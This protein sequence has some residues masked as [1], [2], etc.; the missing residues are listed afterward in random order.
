MPAKAL[1][2]EL[3]IVIRCSGAHRR[4]HMQITVRRAPG[5]GA[6]LVLRRRHAN[7]ALVDDIAEYDVRD[8][9]LKVLHR[10]RGIANDEA[11]AEALAMPGKSA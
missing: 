3:P 10:C 9:V 1:R 7:A 2:C 11:C 5:G 4:L 6:A 8:L